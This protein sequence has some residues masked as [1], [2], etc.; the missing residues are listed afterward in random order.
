MW[1]LLSIYDDFGN[2]AINVQSPEIQSGKLKVPIF[3]LPESSIFVYLFAL[4]VT[5]ITG[6]GNGIVHCLF[7]SW[8]HFPSEV[9]RIFWRVN[10][11][12]AAGFC[13]VSFFITIITSMFPLFYRL[14]GLSHFALDITLRVFN[15]ASVVFLCLS[16]LPF[17]IA[18]LILLFESFFCLQS[19]PKE[20]LE[21]VP[22]TRY[23]PHFF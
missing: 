7:W 12:T 1:P 18:R 14:P 13:A 9:A 3:Y 8:G 16:L 22:W 21:I 6:M 5:C 10:S 15:T 2:L 17:V 23:I 20:A 11:V 4:S 19:L